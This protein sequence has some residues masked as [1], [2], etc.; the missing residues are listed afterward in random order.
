MTKHIYVTDNQAE[1]LVVLARLHIMNPDLTYEFASALNSF[2]W[3]LTD[4]P[5]GRFL[6]DRKHYARAEDWPICEICFLADPQVE[7]YGKKRLCPLHKPLTT[8]EKS[9]EQLRRVI[10]KLFSIAEIA[11]FYLPGELG[12]M[13]HIIRDDMQVSQDLLMALGYIDTPRLYQQQFGRETAY[14]NTTG[15]MR[16]VPNQLQDLQKRGDGF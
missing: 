13:P 16:K 12:E 8:E 3:Q 5:D 4:K 10:L 1:T 2:I 9:E 7:Q 11:E 14:D 15:D 6:F